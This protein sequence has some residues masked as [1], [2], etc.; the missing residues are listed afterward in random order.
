MRGCLPSFL[1]VMALAGV[2]CA[3]GVLADEAKPAAGIVRSAGPTRTEQLAVREPEHR[4]RRMSE[5]ELP[6]RDE[7]YDLVFST[8][9]GGGKWEHARDVFADLAGNVYV[10]GGTASPDFPTTPGVHDRTFNAGGKKIGDAGQCDAFVA[11][12][13]AEGALLWSTFLGGPNYDRAYGVEVDARGHVYVAGR[14]GPGFP[15]TPGAFQTQYGGNGYNGFYGDQNGF[16]A[17]L[18]P[19]G[20]S[21]VWSS[22]VGVGELCR[23]LA[24]D[25]EGDIYL[26][27]GFNTQS[28]RSNRPKWFETA[29]V[30]AFQKKPRGNLDC[31][32]VKVLSNGS[33]VAWATWLG[34][35]GKDTQEAS[36][37][38]DAKKRVTIAFN[39]ESKDMPTTAR[40]SGRKHKGNADGYIARL[41]PNGSELIY[42]TYLGGA[43]TEWLI[44]THNLAIDPQGNAYLALV[45]ASPDFPTTPGACDRTLDGRNDIAIV[46][47]SPAGE[48]LR[49]TFIGGSERENPDGIYADTAGR[50]FF[51]GETRSDDF[52]VT[53]NAYQRTFAGGRDAVV[54]R[55]SFDFGRLL[56]STYMGGKAFDN[57]RSGCLGPDGSLYVTGAVDGAGWPIKNAHQPTFAGGA[58]GWGNG[59]CILAR[60]KPTQ[61]TEYPSLNELGWEGAFRRTFGMPSEDF[62]A[63]FD[64]LLEKPLAD[65]LA[66][67]PKY[68]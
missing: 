54:V 1:L 63:E 36:I 4:V 62:Y 41:N 53:S 66:I 44:N 25:S 52:P 38:V 18:A 2:C 47:L 8:Y 45:T 56:Y 7:A 23:D 48:L 29:F 12:F 21:L 64:A 39:T 3:A 33:R 13:S 61:A 34:G 55:L 30:N 67:L 6:I 5:A 43:N 42:G 32:V 65:Q 51:V 16:V 15:V 40:A 27:L 24:I 60:F 19:D 50:V 68:D 20:T 14:A 35:P 46:K 26:P 9:L 17:K 49:S 57:G 58:G 37:R 31:G 22:Y 59:D 10:V 11:K 28:A